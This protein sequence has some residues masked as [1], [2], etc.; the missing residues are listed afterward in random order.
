MFHLI[1]GELS[2]VS[3]RQLR[4]NGNRKMFV[5]LFLPLPGRGM[6]GC[7]LRRAQRAPAGRQETNSED[8]VVHWSC[9][10]LVVNKIG[11]NFDQIHTSLVTERLKVLWRCV[12][13]RQ[14]KG[15]YVALCPPF[16]LFIWTKA[17]Y[18]T[19]V[20]S[21]SWQLR[22]VSLFLLDLV[23]VLSDHGHD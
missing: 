8:N 7:F 1:V 4:R 23:K 19:C 5:I 22:T 9:W 12:T 10:K 11:E 3:F 15:A 18:S 16:C 17:N 21:S 14:W 13:Y 6:V 2:S 20:M